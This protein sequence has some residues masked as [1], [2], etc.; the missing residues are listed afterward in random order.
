MTV[1]RQAWESRVTCATSNV[2]ANEVLVSATHRGSLMDRMLSP[3]HLAFWALLSSVAAVA[4][5]IIAAIALVPGQSGGLVAAGSTPTPTTAAAQPSTNPSGS[6]SPTATPSEVGPSS[7]PSADPSGVPGPE[8]SYLADRQTV[9]PALNKGSQKVDATVYPHSLYQLTCPSAC[10]PPTCEYDLSRSWT[11]LH[12]VIGVSDDS[13]DANVV[14]QFEVFGDSKALVP[15]RRMKLGEHFD[16][17]ANV[18]GVLRLKMVISRVSGGGQATGVWG[19][20]AL[21]R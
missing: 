12:A 1:A 13:T 2:Q 14:L 9:G 3:R 15:A 16:L 4:G 10:G 21:M 7:S 20:A 5:V 18:T 19:D 8:I 11:K 6:P 17:T